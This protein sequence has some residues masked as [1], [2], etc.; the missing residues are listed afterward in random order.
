MLQI[1]IRPLTHPECKII[2]SINE[3]G[4]PGTG[5]VSEE[6][7][8]SLLDFSSYSIGAYIEE[9][10]VGFV[11]CLPPNTEY[12]SL[13]YAWFNQ[14]YD[15]FLYVDRIAVSVENQNQNIGSVLYEHVKKQAQE[16]DIP[17]TAEVNIH[18]PNPGSMRFHDR[19]GFVQVGVLDHGEKSVALFVYQE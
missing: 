13:N 8:N 9:K 18:P 14:R 1:E 6:E 16:M 7:I 17:V 10:M 2:W 4:L 19:H 5:K 12:G 3:E 15:N 11:I